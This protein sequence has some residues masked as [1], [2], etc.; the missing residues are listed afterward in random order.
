MVMLPRSLPVWPLGGAKEFFSNSI[1]SATASAISKIFSG[2][3]APNGAYL[4]SGG[5]GVRGSNLGARP[6][7]VKIF[8]FFILQKIREINFSIN[9]SIDRYY[10]P[11]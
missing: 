9:L 4:S 7:E 6:P 5:H 3:C 11:L 8:V 1:F 2:S 10:G